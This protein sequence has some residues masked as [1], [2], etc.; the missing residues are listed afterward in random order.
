MHLPIQVS[1]IVLALLPPLLA[2]D[3][4]HTRASLVAEQAWVQPGAVQTV[5][6]RLEMDE[7]WHTYWRNPGDSGLPTEISWSLPEGL[8]AGELQWP[9]P[10]IFESEAGTSYGYAKEVWLLCDLQAS[11]TLT[12]GVDIE[13]RARVDWLECKEACIPGSAELSLLLPV[14]NEEP[15]TLRAHRDAFRDTRKAMPGRT[16]DASLSAWR[17]GNVFHASLRDLP[18]NLLPLKLLAREGGVLDHGATPIIHHEAD[19]ATLLLPASP[20]LTEAPETL[21]GLLICRRKGFF[22]SRRVGFQVDIPL[23]VAT[24]KK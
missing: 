16:V 10:E 24:E 20:W 14:R 2:E 1:L 3:G 8:Q 17:S 13:L 11:P 12:V 4:F 21:K 5:A 18:R 23:A 19:E 15:R 7:G 6:L 9:L 22:G